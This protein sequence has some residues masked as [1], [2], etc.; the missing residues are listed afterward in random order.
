MVR[1]LTLGPRLKPQRT[2]AIAAVLFDDH[3]CFVKHKYRLSRVPFIPTVSH[4]RPSLLLRID[5]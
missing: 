1:R 4:M 2:E 5:V 3:F